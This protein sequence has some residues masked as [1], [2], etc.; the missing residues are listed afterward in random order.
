MSRS[1]WGSFEKNSARR[2]SVG[3]MRG[4][5]WSVSSDMLVVTCSWVWRSSKSIRDQ[6]G[7]RRRCRIVGFEFLR[8]C[9]ER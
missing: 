3:G 1:S 5:G 2:A 8:L 4:D 7:R 9:C 6:S